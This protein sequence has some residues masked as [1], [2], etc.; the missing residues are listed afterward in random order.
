MRRTGRK[1]GF[2]VKELEKGK[3]HH[4]LLRS[5]LLLRKVSVLPLQSLQIQSIHSYP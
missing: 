1:V 2:A 5:T 3:I 4:S